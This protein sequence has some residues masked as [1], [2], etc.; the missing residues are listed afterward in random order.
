MRRATVWLFAATLAMQLGLLNTATAADERD[1]ILRHA[2]AARAALA[3]FASGRVLAFSTAAHEKSRGIEIRL[4]YPASWRTKDGKRPRVVQQFLGAPIKGGIAPRCLL[5]IGAMGEEGSYSR[6]ELLE[7][8]SSE[9]AHFFL[10]NGAQLTR[11]KRTKVEE[12]PTMEVEY[13]AVSER[14]GQSL[15]MHTL[16]WSIAYE[17]HWLTIMCSVG[18]GAEVP[19]ELLDRVF[20]LYQPVFFQIANSVVL[21]A[22]YRR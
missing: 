17:K 12:L 10:P 15:R 20:A 3:D 9:N 16:Q 7:L 18:D 2:A 8:L 19:P 6:A 4:D 21:P 22:R 5:V 11:A 13:V 1:Y 14:A